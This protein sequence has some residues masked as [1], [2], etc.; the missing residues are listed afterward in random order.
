MEWNAA[1][2]IELFRISSELIPFGSHP[3]N[4]VE[5][6]RILGKPPGTYSRSISVCKFLEFYETIHD[7]D[8]NIMLEVKDKQ[9]SVLKLFRSLRA[10]QL[11]AA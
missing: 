7:L 9:E 8:V 10:R 1:R 11:R 5:C 3:V 4:Q 2:G 6:W